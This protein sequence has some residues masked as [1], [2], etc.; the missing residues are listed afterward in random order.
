MNIIPK[1]HLTFPKVFSRLCLSKSV[2]PLKWFWGDGWKWGGQPCGI[3]NHLI[4]ADPPQTRL[5]ILPLVAWSKY[6][7]RAVKLWNR[8]Q[9]LA[10]SSLWNRYITLITLMLKAVLIWHS[11]CILLVGYSPH[12]LW[13]F[14]ICKW[15]L[16][17]VCWMLMWNAFNVWQSK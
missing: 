15:S 12:T 13:L 16:M 6:F 9:K 10:A 1:L 7:D 14:L 17:K 4:E 5:A 2:I 11:I 3:K 8:W